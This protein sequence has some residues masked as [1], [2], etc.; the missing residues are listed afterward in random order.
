MMWLLIGVYPFGVH[1]FCFGEH[2]RPTTGGTG[3]TLACGP[4]VG[5]FW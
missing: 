5:W 2:G 4:F 1:N 3:G